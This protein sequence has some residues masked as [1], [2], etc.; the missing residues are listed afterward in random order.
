MTQ[1]TSCSFW[2][3]EGC[4]SHFPLIPSLRCVTKILLPSTFPPPLP[5]ILAKIGGPS[6]CSCS[7]PP[8]PFIL[9]KTGG[10][11]TCS[12]FPLLPLALH[13]QSHIPLPPPFYFGKNWRT[14][15]PCAPLD[16]LSSFY[17]QSL[18]IALMKWCEPNI[19]G[20]FDAIILS[21][22]FPL[23][24][25]FWWSLHSHIM[26]MGLAHW[27]LHLGHL[28]PCLECVSIMGTAC[29]M[30]GSRKLLI[31]TIQILHCTDAQCHSQ[32]TK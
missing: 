8:L 30:Q 18:Y 27:S 19:S 23:T 11:S 21:L 10:P 9:A 2:T 22:A 29:L 7:P 20:P 24:W 6:T 14:H 31:Y 12:C 26:L 5:F 4:H 13:F 28:Q 1:P 32:T 3:S 15:S 25:K 16:N 17:H